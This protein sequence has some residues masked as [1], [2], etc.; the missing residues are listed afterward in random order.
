LAQPPWKVFKKLARNENILEGEEETA[1]KAKSMT[2]GIAE[3]RPSTDDP[4]IT[5]LINRIRDIFY[6]VK[7]TTREIFMQNADE[8]G[9]K[10]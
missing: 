7:K 6:S 2:A 1:K 5:P 4:T 9:F 3:E 8:K 10:K